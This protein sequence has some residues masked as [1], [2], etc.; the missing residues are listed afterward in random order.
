MGRL[1]VAILCTVAVVAFSM[2]NTHHV[3]LSFVVGETVKIRLISLLAV[4]FIAGALT[5]YFHQAVTRVTR[6]AERSDR[7]S[8]ADLDDE[9]EAHAE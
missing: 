2:T 4:T 8:S 7:R 5:V 3:E 1:I 9:M 6:G